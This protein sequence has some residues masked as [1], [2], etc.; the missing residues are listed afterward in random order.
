MET[1]YFEEFYRAITPDEQRSVGLFRRDGTVLARHPHLDTLIGEK[2]S[3]KSPWYRSVAE[4]GG[5]YRT[6]SRDIGGVARIVSVQPVREYPLVVTTGISQEAALSDWRS[7]S[8]VIV[9]GALSM[10]IGFAI[11]FGALA[12]QSRRVEGRTAELAQTA[13]ALRNS[14]ERFA[15]TR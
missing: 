6:S 3:P 4:G 10:A 5:T 13:D 11:L 9:L 2:I 8:I 7:Y 15:I 14:E 1:R 12:R